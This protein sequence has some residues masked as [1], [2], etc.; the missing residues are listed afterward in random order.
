MPLFLALAQDRQDSVR[1]HTID[2]AVAL[3]KVVPRDVVS[4]QILS[5]VFDTARD[6][7]WRVRWS[8]ANR[9]P[10]ICDAV[11][12]ETVNSSMCDCFSALLEDSE[13]EVRT[14][15]TSKA[16]G[17]TKLFQ[18]QRIVEKIVPS[19][20]TLARD[21]SDHVRSALAAVVMKIS[22]FLG[23][24][25][26][27]E[28]LLPLFL[29]VRLVVLR[30]LTGSSHGCASTNTA[31]G[32]S[33]SLC[34]YAAPERPDVGSAAERDLEPRR[35]QQRTSLWTGVVCYS[36]RRSATTQTHR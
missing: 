16:V 33:L 31:L 17:V 20:Q 2:N 4:A 6:G 30:S 14:S 18:P 24:D 32:L 21:L 9:F 23:R 8:V 25:L 10:E 15:A 7:S 13:A 11:S 26:T 5:T 29:L 12:P 1:I 3:A 34:G 27:I 22:P 35:R 28:H 36:K 19:F